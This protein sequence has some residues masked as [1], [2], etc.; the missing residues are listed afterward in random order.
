MLHGWENCFLF[1][2]KKEIYNSLRASIAE[3][4]KDTEWEG[5]VY[6]VGGCV[7]DEIM[8]RHI[9]DIDLAVTVP[10]GGVLFALWLHKHGLT[11]KGR[12]PKVFEHF[13]TAKVR[14]SIFPKEEIDCVQT[15]K[16]RYVYEEIPRPLEYFGTIEEDAACRDLT[17]NSLYVNVSTGELLDP[18]G[19]GLADIENEV[20]RTPSNPDISL[21]DNAMHILRCIRFAV[22]FGWHL[23][24]ELIESMKRNV[25]IVSEATPTRM[26][27]ELL[28]IQELKNKERAFKLIEKVGAMPVVEEAM[29]R[30]LQ[31]GKKRY[32]QRRKKKKRR[33]P[34]A[35]SKAEQPETQ[36]R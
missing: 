13:G 8:Q 28:A 9:H 30:G 16:G 36:S 34:K 31:V 20:I 2:M 11:P 19:Y 7:R 21:R 35:S 24:D 23:S 6:L 26:A 25:D 22:R 32:P 10:N 1:R 15:R 4:I 17:I 27:K 18:T 33:Y 14:L 29:A 5:Q 12:K 3:I